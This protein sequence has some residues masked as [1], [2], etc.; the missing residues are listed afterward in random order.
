MMWKNSARIVPHSVGFDLILNEEMSLLYEEILKQIKREEV[1]Y[2]Y[3]FEKTVVN[4]EEILSISGSGTV[5][6][7]VVI[8]DRND[9]TIV[10]IKDGIVIIHDTIEKLSSI[11]QFISM[12][13]AVEYR[14]VYL[15][16]I[17]DVSFSTEFRVSVIPSEQTHIN[18]FYSYTKV[19][20]E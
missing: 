13:E 2:T 9:L 4:R 15:F 19:K 1:E 20:Q 11:S 8:S 16:R 7:V 18:V 14:D 6:E 3:K 17:K 5:K 12:F 10:W